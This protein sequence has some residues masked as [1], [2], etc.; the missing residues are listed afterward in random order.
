MWLLIALQLQTQRL[1]AP[2][3]F[4]LLTLGLCYVLAQNYVPPERR[5]RL[6]PDVSP[7]VATVG[8][9]IAAN[10]AVTLMWRHIPPSWKL[11]NRFFVIVPFYPHSVSMIGSMF[12]HQT[13]KHLFTNM[14]VL[15]LM[16]TRGR[17]PTSVFWR[18]PL[19]LPTKFTMSSAVETSWPSIWPQA[20][21]AR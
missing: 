11:L 9:I 8:T 16:G 10:V 7:A 6:W 5:D 12:S 2:L 14:L 18:S 1:L 13:F 3:L 15:A 17:S 4:S 20:W 19:I 21:W